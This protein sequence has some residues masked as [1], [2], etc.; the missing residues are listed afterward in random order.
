MT[1]PVPN[2]AARI[3]ELLLDNGANDALIVGGFVRDSILGRQSK[4]IDIE[5]YGLSIDDIATILRNSSYRVDEV[6][7]SFGVLKVNQ[8]IDISIPRK[9]SR[10]GVGHKGFRVQFDPDM[11]FEQAAARRDFTINAMGM[12][13]DGSIVDPYKG[14]Y[15]MIQHYLAHVSSAFAEDPLRP[16]RA[17]QFAGRFGMDLPMSTQEI[18]RRM[19]HSYHQLPKER[20]WEEWKKWALKSVKPSDGLIVLNQTTW[21]RH[22]PEIYAL[23]HCEQDPEWHPEGSVYTHTKHV[24]DKAVEI[25]ERENLDTQDR[26]ILVFAALCHDFGKPSTTKMIDGRWRSPGHC[27]AGLELI[28]TFME[29]IGAPLWLID[30]VKRLTKEH[31]VHMNKPTARTIRRLANRLKHSN[32]YMLSLLVE[33]DASGRPPLPHRSPMAEWVEMAKQLKVDN[34]E[35]KPILLGRHLIELGVSPGPIMGHILEQAFQA[36][37]DG[38]FDS[39]D[40]AINWYQ[41][42]KQKLQDSHVT[43]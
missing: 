22:Y 29:R 19:F 32:I 39:L 24:L 10:V 23:A 17:F 36:Q 6:G 9:E 14:R 35:P 37:L 43:P 42:H 5:V 12:R 20:I 30:P 15:D 31:L 27:E 28:D 3:M 11:T 1:N 40:Q 18:C 7:K 8:D 26:L 34:G 2:T 16:L 41:L 13:L 21:I 25:A 4:D 33:A 38:K